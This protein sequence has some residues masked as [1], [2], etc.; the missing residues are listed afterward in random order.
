MSR[1]WD[2]IKERRSWGLHGMVQKLSLDPNPRL[3][4]EGQMGLGSNSAAK[5]GKALSSLSLDLLFLADK[6]EP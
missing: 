5:A 1:K 3:G 4:S 2:R 6:A